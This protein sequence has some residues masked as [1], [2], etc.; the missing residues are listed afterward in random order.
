MLG[1][2]SPLCLFVLLG[3]AQ[4]EPDTKP[5]KNPLPEYAGTIKV[6]IKLVSKVD[7][8]VLTDFFKGKFKEQPRVALQAIDVVSRFHSQT[9]HVPVGRAV[10][11]PKRQD[12]VSELG[13]GC[14]VWHGHFST[15]RPTQNGLCLNIDT[16]N[17]AMI[18]STNL[19]NFLI[20]RLNRQHP[21]QLE[22]RD[23]QNMRRVLKG[24]RVTTLHRKSAKVYRISGLSQLPAS[25]DMFDLQDGTKTSVAE[26]FEKKYKKLA[27]PNLPCVVVGTGKRMTTLPMEAC[28]V[29][30]GQKQMQTLDSA[31]RQKMLDLTSSNPQ[32]REKFIADGIPDSSQDPYLKEFRLQMNNKMMQV[33]ARVLQPP[34]LRFSSERGGGPMSV[35]PNNGQWALRDAAFLVRKQIKSS[36]LLIVGDE[37]V[38]NKDLA[39][40]CVFNLKQACNMKGVEFKNDPNPWWRLKNPNEAQQAIERIYT[41]TQKDPSKRPDIIF[42]FLNGT[43]VGLASFERSSVASFCV[44]FP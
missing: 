20:Q 14:V 15:V 19:L 33:P 4:W 8:S 23:M 24:I 11:Y 7:F 32:Q 25:K 18:K 39:A 44:S 5:R 36:A 3:C 43:Y 37:R 27:F 1:C 26:Y 2:V 21:S 12:M 40:Q 13:G 38:I 31:Q 6:D 30:D 17:V 22:P 9:V 29:V 16:A 28:H 41:E 10:Y 35:R 42:C 34:A